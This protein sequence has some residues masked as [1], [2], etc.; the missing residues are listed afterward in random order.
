MNEQMQYY[1]LVRD[2][3]VRRV[4][5]KEDA[6]DLTQEVFLKILK[7]NPEFE[8]IQNL[9]GWTFTVA[10]NKLIDY[11]R[12]NRVEEMEIS[13]RLD[14][15]EKEETGF[16]NGMEKCI[17]KFLTELDDYSKELITAIDFQGISQKDLAKKLNIPY[18]TLRS[19][20]QRARKKV[21]DRFMSICDFYYDSCGN[22]IDCTLKSASNSC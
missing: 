8:E 7:N 12:K 11:Y 16:Y 9:G 3:F 22:L 14:L 5:S 6:L 17:P 19:H 10:R 18:P 2:F 1:D 13:D 20:V 21:R 15:I 4:K